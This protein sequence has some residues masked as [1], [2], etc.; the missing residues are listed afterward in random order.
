MVMRFNRESGLK[1]Q[2]SRAMLMA[3][4]GKRFYLTASSS[5]FLAP[6]APEKSALQGTP[7]AKSSVATIIRSRVTLV[8]RITHSLGVAGHSGLG[9]DNCKSVGFL[10]AT[11]H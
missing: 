9:V 1:L 4:S 6:L 8:G 7:G 5:Q 2:S 10:R 11:L 3:V